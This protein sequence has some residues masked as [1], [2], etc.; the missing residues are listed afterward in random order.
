[1]SLKDAFARFPRLGL[2]LAA[3]GR[4]GY[5]NVGHGQDLPPDHNPAT[6]EAQTHEMLD[7]AWE[8][9]IRYMD[10]ARSYGRG[11]EFLGNWLKKREFSEDVP[12]IGSKWGYT[13]TAD[14]QVEAEHHEIKEHSLPVLERQWK[15]SQANL[16]SHLDLYQI[17]SATLQSGV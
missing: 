16:G 7:L 6:M 4:P 11:E 17:H 15:E 3:L 13:Y 1:M 9:G 10:V 14:W 2:G 5:I 12:T 8:H